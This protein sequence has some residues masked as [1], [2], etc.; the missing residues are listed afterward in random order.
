MVNHPKPAKDACP[1]LPVCP[2]DNTI[3]ERRVVIAYTKDHKDGISLPSLDYCPRC[4]RY[5]DYE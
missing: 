4:S 2:D 3:L 5:I 1:N